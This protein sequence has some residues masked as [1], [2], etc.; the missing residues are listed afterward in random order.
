MKSTTLPIL[1]LVSVLPGARP[2]SS[3][4]LRPVEE[5]GDDINVRFVPSGSAYDRRQEDVTGIPPDFL[6]QIHAC[7]SSSSSGGNE[8]GPCEE[9]QSI[10]RSCAPNGTSA[11]SML[12]HAHCLCSGPFFAEWLA[13]LDCLV[14][15][16]DEGDASETGG[17]QSLSTAT[18]SD[19]GAAAASFFSSALSTAS[20]ALCTGTPLV[21][22][23]S[24][25]AAGVRRL[26]LDAGS[27]EKRFPDDSSDSPS[28]GVDDALGVVRYP[29]P[30]KRQDPTDDPFTDPLAPAPVPSTSAPLAT[31]TSTDSSSTSTA[32][33]TD[34]TTG[35]DGVTETD[36]SIIT[37]TETVTATIVVDPVPAD[38]D[39]GDDPSTTDSS[40]ETVTTTFFV[41]PTISFDVPAPAPPPATASTTAPAPVDRRAVQ[42]NSADVSAA[43]P[44]ERWA[45]IT[46]VAA[47]VAAAAALA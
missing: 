5:G 28:G 42:G 36:T 14:G 30:W 20:E 18:P 9:V 25:Y 13:C 21:P 34:S 33:A 40:T 37:V 22:F 4:S 15:D 41:V 2:Q 26:E 46:V 12:N 1:A 17:P 19:I 24:V 11:E 8:T 35:T 39:G 32:P 31:A 45:W 38:P 10:E 6:P 47:L 29:H 7:S 43:P 3:A 27:L 23:R 44:G 16:D